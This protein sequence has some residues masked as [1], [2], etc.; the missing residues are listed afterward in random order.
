[1]SVNT[2]EL[3]KLSFNNLRGNPVVDNH[4]ELIKNVKVKLRVVVGESEISVG[5][6][7]D[8]KENSVLK[9][10]QS[11]SAPVLVMLEDRIIARGNLVAVDD[12]F[13]IQITEIH[14]K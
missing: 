13:G 5:E 11:V 12:N 3:E 2:I 1:M 7:Y 4:L 14:K 6:L 10:D 9:L 8:L